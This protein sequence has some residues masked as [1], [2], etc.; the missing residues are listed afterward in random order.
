[1]AAISIIMRSRNNAPVIGETLRMVYSQTVKD[2]ELIN[3]DNASTDGTAAIIGQY[4]KGGRVMS[5]E[6]GKYIPGAVLNMAVSEAKGEIIVL[7]NSDATP[8]DENW[9]KN[10]V[11]GLGE[12]RG[13][14]AVYGRQIAREDSNP[15]MRRDYERAYPAAGRPETASDTMFSFASAAFRR[16]LWEKI[17]FYENG[18]SEDIEWCRRVQ[19]AGYECAYVPEAAVYHSHRYTLKGL[20]IRTYQEHFPMG[21]IYSGRMNFLILF[22][23]AFAACLRD[24]IFA[25]RSR[26]LPVF[27]Y[28]PFYRAA[29]F[30]GSYLGILKGGRLYDRR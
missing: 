28:S 10:L 19:A 25:V 26:D 22:K 14:D 7:L 21:M 23:R 11:A 4:N 3:V 9:L 16:K 6:N 18:L 24:L 29:I 5:V 15:L 20:M 1:M 30:F 2:F 8:A 13:A 27:F 17:R 12:G